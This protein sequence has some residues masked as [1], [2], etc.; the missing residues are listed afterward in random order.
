MK[1]HSDRRHFFR[2]INALALARLPDILER[3]LPGGRYEGAEYV[4]QN[5]MRE[6]RTPGSF[7]V[8]VKTGR[9]ADFATG[10]KGGDPVSLAAYLSG[11]GQYAAAKELAGMLGATDA[12]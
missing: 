8:N 9:W 12:D 4:V 10:D 11:L 2:T 3:W 6:D 7:K 5:P 1:P